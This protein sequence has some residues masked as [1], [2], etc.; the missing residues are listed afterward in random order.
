MNKSQFLVWMHSNRVKHACVLGKLS[1]L[2]KQ[3]RLRKGVSLE[4]QFPSDVQFSLHPDF[5][6]DLVLT[7]SLINSD[8]LIVASPRL[9]DYLRKNAFIDI[10]YLPVTIRDHKGKTMGSDYRIVH[11]V[12]HAECLNREAS[13]AEESELD[14]SDVT[15]VARLVIYEERVPPEKML[16]RIAEF[17]KVILVR[18]HLA[19]GLDTAGFTGFRW[20]ELS[21]YPE[22]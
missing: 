1:G 22:L 8:M 15:D 21:A 20:L 5:P 10:E 2:E 13:D 6:N 14:P 12:N 19:E 4:R 7:D 17:P 16:F 11:Q 3:F 9:Q 18:R